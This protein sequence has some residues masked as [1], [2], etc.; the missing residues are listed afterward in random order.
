MKL[1]SDK[2][3]KDCSKLAEGIS[4]SVKEKG[5]SRLWEA[6]PWPIPDIRPIIAGKTKEAKL[7]MNNLIKCSDCY[8]LKTFDY[9]EYFINFEQT[10]VAKLTFFLIFKSVT[11]YTYIPDLWVLCL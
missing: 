2:S 3:N 5:K 10:S 8:K 11:N 7:F 6:I 4:C 9:L 1:H